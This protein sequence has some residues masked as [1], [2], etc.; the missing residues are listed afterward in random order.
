MVGRRRLTLAP[1]NVAMLIKGGD[2]EVK[3]GIEKRHATLLEGAKGLLIAVV[4]VFSD[5]LGGLL[6]P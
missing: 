4:L 5:D 6:A 2:S 1:F 3:L